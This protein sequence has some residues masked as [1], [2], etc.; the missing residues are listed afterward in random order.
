LVKLDWTG[1]PLFVAGSTH[2]EEE[3]AVLAA[4]ER[5]REAL[6]SLR[7]VAAP[8]HVERAASAAAALRAGGRAVALWSELEGR[9]SA[10]A[11]ILV[12]DA[13]GV[14]PAFWPKA[15]A[16]FVGGTLAPVGGHNLLEPAS[17]GVPVMFGPHTG[18]IELP[19]AELERGGGGLRVADADALGQTLLG[20]LMDPDGARA[21]G[22]KALAA[23]EGLRGASRRTLDALGPRRG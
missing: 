1:R 7:L 3:P 16:A 23:A 2:A 14:L 8:R 5:A 13:M 22:A 18:H 10:D 19:A 21:L 20:L 12:V 9:M 11:D 17:A 15:A 4:Y 6:P